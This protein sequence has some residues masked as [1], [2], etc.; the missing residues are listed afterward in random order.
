MRAIYKKETLQDPEKKGETY[1][2]HVLLRETKFCCEKFQEHCKKFTAWSYVHGK[3]SI[4]D[5]I[6]YEKHSVVIINFCPFCGE[7]IEYEDID[8]LKK[9]YN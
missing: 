4:V 9:T 6:S 2:N 7:S 8:Y 3:F 1:T 5:Q